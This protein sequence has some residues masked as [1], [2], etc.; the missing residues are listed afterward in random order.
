MKIEYAAKVD[1]GTKETNDDRVL[2]DGTIINMSSQNGS[3]D[4]PGIAVVCDGCGGYLG[5]NIA[6]QSVLEVI[7]DENVSLLS[8]ISYL[9]KVL[10]NCEA[11]VSKK[12]NEMP[13]YPTM[14]TTIAGCVFL[15]DST[16][17]FHSGDSRVYRHDRWGIA[18]MTK[19]HSVV[20]E[21]IDEGE[22]TIQEAQN[23]PKRNVIS[24][25]I[26]IEGRP[27]EIYV[28]HTPINP[29]E[30]Y[31]LCSDGL[32]ESVSDDEIQE[33]LGGELSIQDAADKLVQLALQKGSDDNISVCI[34][35]R[36]GTITVQENKPFILD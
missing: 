7:S 10:N 17:I 35:S 23:H 21:M 16:I 11:A 30:K 26:G 3:I 36:E 28:S 19:D 29:G 18:R 15:A 25:C 24:R 33:I 9:S 14:C 13:E 8:D 32:W 4:I 6:A 27:P 5:G 22:I 31:L 12:K 1:I 34:C 2:I 20:Q